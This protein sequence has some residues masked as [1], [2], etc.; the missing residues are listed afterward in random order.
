MLMSMEIP[1][2]DQ[3]LEKDL[4]QYIE[5]LQKPDPTEGDVSHKANDRGYK[6]PVKHCKPD[7]KNLSIP[8][9]G[10]VINHKLKNVLRKL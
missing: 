3:Y 4:Q 5:S 10:L 1:C 2:Q 8:K 7:I 6:L 9:R